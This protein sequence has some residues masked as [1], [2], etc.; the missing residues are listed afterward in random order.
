M[1]DGLTLSGDR[2]AATY[3]LRGS[4]DEAAATAADICIEQTVEFPADLVERADIRD[5][6]FGRVRSLRRIDGECCEAVIEFAVEIAGGEL[7]QLLNVLFGNISLEPGIRLV[8]LDLPPSL[9]RSFAGPRFGRRGLRALLG[10]GARP[11]V[12]TALKPMG[13]SPTELADQAHRYALGGIDLIKE[14][15]G[16]ADQPFCPF[17][18]RVQRC[19]E[20]VERANRESGSGCLY[21]PNV[22]APADRVVD[23]A[24]FARDAGAGGLLVAPGLTGFDTM[25]R[26]A[27]DDDIDLPILGHPAL[28]G[29]LGLRPDEGMSHGVLYGLIQRL[30]GAD[31]CIFPS[32][33][34]RFSFTPDDCLDLV[35]GAG[36]DLGDL[37]R[38]FP[39]PAGGMSLQRVPEMVRFYGRDVILLIGGD[40]HRHGPDLTASCREFS[41][42][43][44]DVPATD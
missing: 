27:A 44:R 24:R 15:H 21:L 38:L 4:E 3:R 41:R 12:C 5:Q 35:H 23:R 20:A 25:R 39:V 11:L 34:G 33:G 42:L 31:G 16:L 29:G 43:V 37:R 30:A 17:E 40:L 14:D 28:L 22:T 36:A 9:L 1:A 26:L 7:T 13:L 10:A 2:F 8:G 19:A 18:E 32:Y 6:V